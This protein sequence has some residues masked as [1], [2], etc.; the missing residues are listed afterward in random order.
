MGL[1]PTSTTSTPRIRILHLSDLHQRDSE[2]WRSRQVLG[3]AWERN[4]DAVLA[5]GPVDIVCFTGDV[6]DQGLAEEYER[7]TDFFD[8]PLEHLQLQRD[9]LFV[10]P[11]NHD[12]ARHTE[13]DAWR[14]VR[15][16]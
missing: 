13:R 4:L 9:R 1:D 12:I 3:E 5:D 14:A 10:V 6:A 16:A 11:G 7:A 8:S 2:H 15:D